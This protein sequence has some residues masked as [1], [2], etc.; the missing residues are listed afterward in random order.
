MGDNDGHNAGA[1]GGASP[2]KVTTGT[3]NRANQAAGGILLVVMAGVFWI[4]GFAGEVRNATTKNLPTTG[5]TG[6]QNTQTVLG[7]L[8]VL[9]AIFVVIGFGLLLSYFKRATFSALF[10]SIFT[11]SLTAI[12]SPILQKLWFNIFITNFQGAAPALTDPSRFMQ[13]SLGGSTIYLDYYNLKIMLANSIAQLVTILA[14]FGRLNPAQIIVNSVGFNFC[15]NL[16]YFLCALLATNS[17]DLRIYDD[18]QINCVYLFAACYGLIASLLIRQPTTPLTPEFSSNNNST[19]TAHLGTFFLFL[20]FCVTTTLYTVKYTVSSGETQ[21]AFIWQ[22]AFISTFVALSASVVS[23]YAFSVLFNRNYRLGIRG[24][25][26]GTITGAIIYGPVAGT[27]INIG[28]AIACGIFAGFLSALF[29]EK[30]FPSING[31]TVKDSFGVMGILIV[32]FIGTFFISPIVLKTYYNYSVDLP[33][34]YP[35][36]SPSTAYFIGN[37]DAVGWVLIYVGVSM[38][39]GLASGLLIGLLMRAI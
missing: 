20:A 35:Q 12:V 28:A 9:T 29:F 14:L 3:P 2:T 39:I 33:T 15:W 31:R 16:N 27:C 7:N 17:P 23:T 30:I 18:Y 22:E 32:S 24:S 36:N 4:Y 21:R 5:L 26:V 19:V 10:V 11:V 13:Y 37:K 6:S 1:A 25:L 34:L 8:F 38:G